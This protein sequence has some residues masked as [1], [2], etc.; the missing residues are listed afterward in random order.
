MS[1]ILT[2]FSA[3]AENEGITI[4]ALEKQ[5]GASKGVLSR[6]LKNGTDIQAKWLLRLVENYP[7]YNPVW[8]LTSTGPM[9][10]AKKGKQDTIQEE[11]SIYQLPE[12]IKTLEQQLESLK[13]AN[14]ALKES[15]TSLKEIKVLLEQRITE[16]ENK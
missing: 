11:A 9:I 5:I 8:I 7:E 14:V 13:E 16:L 4:S 1:E 2:V 3:I 6:A 10:K 15:N 12:K